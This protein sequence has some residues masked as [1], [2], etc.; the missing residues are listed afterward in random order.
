MTRAFSCRVGAASV[1]ALALGS[2]ALWAQSADPAPDTG[3]AAQ[4][5]ILQ[6]V[7]SGQPG[8]AELAETPDLETGS[9][10]ETTAEADSATGTSMDGEASDPMRNAQTGP[11][12]DAAAEDGSAPMTAGTSAETTGSPDGA[13]GATGLSG[14]AAQAEVMKSVTGGQSAPIPAQGNSQSAETDAANPVR[15]GGDAGATE[16]AEGAT[17]ESPVTEHM[18]QATGMVSS[19]ESAQAEMMGAMK[20]EDGRFTAMKMEGL[21]RQIYQSAYT[22]GYDDA[23]ADMHARM[24][25]MMEGVRP[26]EDKVEEKRQQMSAT[27]PDQQGTVIMVPPGMDPRQ[28]LLMLSQQGNR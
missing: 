5:Q 2:G 17:T 23:V 7:T 12:G 19:G 26:T 11:A 24:G 9:D 20:S 6:S 16:T 22:A 3:T 25:S 4:K 21:V 1:L 8:G 13:A 28:V 14:A 10:T 27:F 18:G 15:P